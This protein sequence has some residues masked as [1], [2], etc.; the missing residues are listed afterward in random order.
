MALLPPTLFL[1]DPVLLLGSCGTGATSMAGLLLLEK[2]S[3][4][5]A[6]LAS[7]PNFVMTRGEE[8]ERDKP[9]PFEGVTLG[10]LL[11]CSS[12]GEEDLPPSLRVVR[13]TEH[14]P[15]MP[16]LLLS[17]LVPVVTGMAIGF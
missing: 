9:E 6:T 1:R 11:F 5:C 8:V 15:T 4:R 17:L 2:L 3:R 16:S 7:T 12:L 10:E 14:P 13:T